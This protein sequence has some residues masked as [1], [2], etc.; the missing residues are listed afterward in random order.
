MAHLVRSACT[1]RFEEHE[2]I[3]FFGVI[4]PLDEDSCSYSYTVRRDGMRLDFTVFPIDGDVYADIYRDSVTEPIIRCR[5]QGCT[6]SRF[7][8]TG[9]TQSLETGRPPNATSE[10]DAPLSWGLRL[11]VDPHLKLEI[12]NEK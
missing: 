10:Q 2:F 8:H 6:H 3:G 12:I 7:V 5:L 11:T 4:S 9:S 1:L